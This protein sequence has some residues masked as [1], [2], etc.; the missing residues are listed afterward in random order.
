MLVH[1]K[2]SKTDPFRRGQTIV[3]GRT[4]SNLC[5]ISAMLTY[6]DFRTPDTGPLFSYESGSFLT[7]EKLTRETRSLIS[8]GGLDL[9]G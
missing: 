2:V 3:I 4:T 6:L 7:R 8:K 9:Q 5:P 1:L